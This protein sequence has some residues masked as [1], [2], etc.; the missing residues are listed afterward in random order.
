MCRVSCCKNCGSRYVGCHAEC[1]SYQEWRI[2]KHKEDI[3][4]AKMD[5][6]EG[7]RKSRIL[8]TIQLYGDE[9]TKQKF[10]MYKK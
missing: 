10:G 1:K 3:W 8:H 5:Y 4:L 9:E 7:K 2:E 6:R